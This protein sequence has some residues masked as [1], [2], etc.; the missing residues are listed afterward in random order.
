MRAH[1]DAL[2]NLA[3]PYGILSLQF[4]C[5]ADAVRGI[6][7]AWDG[8]ALQH[9]RSSLY[10]DM[11][12]FA[13]AY[14]LALAALTQRYFTYRGRRGYAPSSTLVWLPLWA[15]LADCLENLFHLCLLS[16][17]TC[18]SP[19]VLVPLACSAALLKWSLLLFWLLAVGGNALFGKRIKPA[20][21][22]DHSD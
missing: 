21:N 1:S 9:A 8:Q 22:G 6:L 4:T 19:D 20:S 15:A 10:W 14:G 16:A 17:D 2:I 13:P 11:S 12:F 7:A 18:V 3:A 5:G